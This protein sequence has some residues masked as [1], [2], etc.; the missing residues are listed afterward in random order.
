MLSTKFDLSLFY[1]SLYRWYGVNFRDLPWRK[2]QD[3]YQIWVS[4]VILQ[5]TQV[6]QGLP[7]Y[8]RFIQA[9][10]TVCDLANSSEDHVLSLWKGLGYYSRAR[11]MHSAA[12]YVR[13]HLDGIFPKQY[14]ALLKL[15]GVGSYTAAAI[16]SFSSNEAVGVLDGNVFRF[17]ARLFAISEPI[18][19]SSGVKL[20]KKIVDEML[21]VNNPSGFNQAVMEFGA[22]HCTPA[23]PKCLVCPFSSY[24]EAF[25]LG[26]VADL[27]VK[28]PTGAKRIR[29]LN[30]LL[31]GTDDAFV[32]ERRSGK[33]IWNGLYQ[34]PLWDGH[35]SELNIEEWLSSFK[36]SLW[37]AA[38]LSNV[39]FLEKIDH[40]LSHQQLT[41]SFYRVKISY[42]RLQELVD[43]NLQFQLLKF[44]DVET[45]AFPVPIYRFLTSV[46]S[47]TK[48]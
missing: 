38:K 20:F 2:T 15:K 6:K 35:L 17:Y 1:N 39:E 31:V 13:D 25:A 30:Y 48:G 29:S 40:T 45:K 16:A 42:D 32:I 24:C 43:N 28:I 27:P 9:F 37:S 47:N 26:K 44:E 36:P 5:Q 4:E 8:N 14:S 41:I 12:M 18:N 33:D 34:L 46:I 23:N 11:N 3:P 7:Y 19:S 21:D 10:P 22:L